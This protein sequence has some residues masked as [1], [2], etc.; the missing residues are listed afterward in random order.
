MAY[1]NHIT[2]GDDMM[3]KQGR[4]YAKLSELKA[5]DKVEVDA[6][7]DCMKPGS[8]KEVKSDAKGLYVDCE[9]DGHYLAGQAD[10][11]EDLIGIYKVMT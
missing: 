2:N 5:G 6:D 9:A 10:N 11:G 1:R 4:E 3:D 7:F 8:E